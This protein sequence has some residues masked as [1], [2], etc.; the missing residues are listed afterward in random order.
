MP[1]FRPVTTKVK[2]RPFPSHGLQY[3]GKASDHSE[4]LYKR[5]LDFLVQEVLELDDDA[6]GLIGQFNDFLSFELGGM[7]DILKDIQDYYNS[8][9]YTTRRL[10]TASARAEKEP[11]QVTNCRYIK[12]IVKP[13]FKIQEKI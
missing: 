9:Q 8:D 10:S 1:S 13:E 4:T 5:E 6:E 11:H 2:I 12:N 7:A 3:S